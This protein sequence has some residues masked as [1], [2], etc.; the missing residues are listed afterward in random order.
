M[1]FLF[2]YQILL[3]QTTINS[4]ITPTINSIINVEAIGLNDSLDMRTTGNNVTWDFSAIDT[5]GGSTDSD[6][7][8]DATK[9]PY[10]SSFPTA[11]IAE[12]DESG[13]YAYYKFTANSVE[14]LGAY[15]GII[16]NYSTPVMIEQSP[17]S[18]GTKQTNIFGGI[19]DQAV[20]TT[21]N[22]GIITTTYDAFG[23]IKFY[24]KTYP[25]LIRLKI[26]KAERD[27]IPYGEGIYET[28]VTISDS[29]DFSIDGFTTLF[30]YVV[31]TSISIVDGVES[32]SSTTYIFEAYTS[33]LANSNATGT[34]PQ[35]TSSISGLSI[36]PNP[37][38]NI[39]SV[40]LN[41]NFGNTTAEFINSCGT[42]VRSETLSE[43]ASSIDL[44][45]LT[46][47]V[48]LVKFTNGSN[49]ETKRIVKL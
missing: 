34:T 4:I 33:N 2:A 18:L 40:S 26:H 21:Y 39:L 24:G 44:S 9:T 19:Y 43:G 16:K 10:Y 31:T 38:Q 35:N 1:P 37:V 48:Y 17:M 20:A 28:L 13:I 7:V 14:L 30:A 15:E 42:P 47:G 46:P 41:N 29:Y 27:S 25:N 5:S 23:S 3:A 12:A 22:S 6:T 11:N 8:L 36:A 49:Q 45:N 32:D